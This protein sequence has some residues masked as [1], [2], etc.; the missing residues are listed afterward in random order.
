MKYTTEGNLLRYNGLTIAVCM[1]AEMAQM[2]AEML[3]I[4][5]EISE[6]RK[7]LQS[8]QTKTNN[9]EKVDK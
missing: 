5:S 6:L 7:E 4:N 8:L 1:D 3:N 9:Y 2:M